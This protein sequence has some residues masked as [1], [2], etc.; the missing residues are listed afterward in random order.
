M[1]NYHFSV[2]PPISRSDGQ[3][4]VA[5]AAYRAGEKIVDE[6]TGKIYDFT[7]KKDVLRST[8][9][10]PENAPSSMSER[11]FL[12]NTVEF[13][14]KRKDAQLARDVEISLPLEFTESQNWDLILSFVQKEMVALGMVADVAMHRGGT[15]RNP[16]PHAHVML[17]MR[18]VNEQGFG[19]K[20]RSWN[21]KDLLMIWR[22]HWAYHCNKRYAELGFDIRIDHRSLEAQGIPLEP[23]NK[24]G[25]VEVAQEKLGRRV[26][27]HQDIARRNGERILA[28]PSI[29][30]YAITR[31]QSTF[32][33]HDIARFVNRQ[34]ADQEQFSE[35]YVKILASNELVY[36]G[37]D[38]KGL[39][40]F[41]TKAQ[42]EL[43]SKMMVEA[44]TLANKHSHKVASKII[45]TVKSKHTLND[46]QALALDHITAGA[47]LACVVGFAGSGKSYLL[48][49][50]REVW[51]AN[52]LR[53]HGVALS[54]IAAQNLEASSGIASR[55]FASRQWY[56]ERDKEHLGAEDVIVVD[57]AGMLSSEQ[58][59]LMVSE[60]ERANA[61]LIL[62]GDPE[63][64]QAINAGAAFRGI[65]DRV[66]ASELN[67]IFRQKEAWQQDATRDLAQRQTARALESYLD[68][69]YVHSY[70]DK[71]KAMSSLLETWDEARGKGA[72]EN[73]IILTYTNEAVKTLNEMARALRREQGELGEDCVVQTA[74]G[75]LTLSSGDRVYFLKGDNQLGVKNGTLG[76]IEAIE[77]D[78]RLWVRLDGIGEESSRVISFMPEQYNDIDLGYAATI[79]KA[80]GVTV[81]NAYVLASRHF[82][83]HVTYVALSRHREAVQ[84]YYTT[85]EFSTFKDL[86]RT[87]SSYH[88]KEFTLDYE[89]DET[90]YHL[91][92]F[93]NTAH[94]EAL[95]SPGSNSIPTLPSDNQKIEAGMK[96]VEAYCEKLLKEDGALL[97]PRGAKLALE[98]LTRQ[99]ST[100]THYDLA[101]FVNKYTRN[102]D[103][104]KKLYTDIL[105]YGDCVYV[106]QD[107]EDRQRFSTQK[108]VAIEKEM[109]ENV[110]HKLQENKS[111]LD[112]LWIE[113]ACMGRELSEEQVVAL[114]HITEGNDLACI[115]GV[116]GAGKSYLLGAAN[117][118][119]QQAGY[120]V[121]G[122]TLSGIAAEKLE[123]GS[124]I[125]SYTMANRLWHWREGRSL[126]TDKDVV[127]VDEAGM[128]GSVQMAA[129]LKEVNK[130]GAKLVL[131]GDPEQLQ[132]ID[133]GGAFRAIAAETGF[134]DMQLVRRQKEA[135]QRE[136]TLQLASQKTRQA[137]EAYNNA[138]HIHAEK[139]PFSKVMEAWDAAR[140]KEPVKSHLMLA[141]SKREVAELNHAAHA[142][143]EE[144]GE[145]GEMVEI[146]T[147]KGKCDMAIG[148][149]IYFHK[150]DNHVLK[151]KNGTMGTIEA[152]NEEKLTVR[153]EGQVEPNES[154]TIA[155]AN[156]LPLFP[157]DGTPEE[158]RI[159]F[160]LE[161]YN[162]IDYGYATT[163]HK[164]QGMT[165]DNAY[166]LAGINFNRH[167]SYVALT[168]HKERVDVFYNQKRF[169]TVEKLFSTMSREK[170][171]DITIDYDNV[172][173]NASNT[174]SLGAMLVSAM[175][176]IYKEDIDDNNYYTKKEWSKAE[177]AVQC[178]LEDNVDL[179]AAERNRLMNLDGTRKD[180]AKEELRPDN[181]AYSDS[182]VASAQSFADIENR[183][184]DAA[185]DVTLETWL[186]DP[187]AMAYADEMVKEY[188]AEEILDGLKSY[189]AGELNKND[190]QELLQ[191]M[192]AALN[193][194][195]V[196]LQLFVR[197]PDAEEKIHHFI[198]AHAKQAELSRSL[199]KDEDLDRSW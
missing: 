70:P 145:L 99:Q 17:T 48:K 101:C 11:S 97:S 175:D 47:N 2:K 107:D 90:A 12:W 66:G 169:K 146:E 125:K 118:A 92:H 75:L 16:Q 83:R 191:Q 157:N 130:R 190:E 44:E 34:S 8:I 21:S 155:R 49:A 117:E 106:G 177:E 46:E 67:H 94:D 84:L 162:Y 40:R 120:S 73:S 164:S 128:L 127:V 105:L 199:D 4:S 192:K 163:L 161:D 108:M 59:A 181:K 183:L 61:K 58:M 176:D 137:L 179:I 150:N 43:E 148:E 27:E 104:F 123:E 138:G 152:I 121:Q 187:T 126:L 14:E 198:A 15:I 149:R 38:E 52:G 113:V 194:N 20:A 42:Y 60:V 112:S 185:L 82:D 98:K 76:T 33:H 91:C 85:D 35:V 110:S 167:A 160:N 111:A 96:R 193:D 18:T 132:A 79:H 139:D 37:L 182:V 62:V 19:L 89:I 100:F 147:A 53:V 135:W 64:L 56:W 165:V 189:E 122:V 31:Q 86:S 131:V 87:L 184:G 102:A 30:L 26:K 197:T 172:Q 171:K 141:Y 158:R 24:R 65:V 88:N 71:E 69:G 136:A 95:F 7:R 151:I 166:V 63:Q 22:A 32:T 1:A 153:L 41:T 103:E 57:E 25:T 159:T 45:A 170:L 54:G 116:A 80:Q 29:A 133:A 144:H 186:N 93:L 154:S 9:L 140:L 50:A 142:C 39:Q 119:W 51:E 81:D 143:L 36:L 129:L 3:S 10:L 114:K 23:Q 180:E 55:T 156:I 68:K 77:E 174:L 72:G 5:C 13:T 168:R 74:E 188:A 78:G 115:V 109:M 134:V 124:H 28:D 173:N 6:R 195:D 178:L 196:M